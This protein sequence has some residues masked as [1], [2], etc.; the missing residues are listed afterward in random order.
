MLKM[1]L[2]IYV[3]LLNMYMEY[4]RINIMNKILDIPQSFYQQFTDFKDAVCYIMDDNFMLRIFFNNRLRSLE[5]IDSQYVHSSHN[6][7]ITFFY[8]L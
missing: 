5:K 1:I 6:E 3:K 8:G 4:E 2:M 7:I